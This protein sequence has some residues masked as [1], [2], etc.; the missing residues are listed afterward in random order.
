MTAALKRGEEVELPVGWVYITKR[1]P[2]R[3]A[4]GFQKLR[5]IADGNK[6]ESVS[7]LVGR[8]NRLICFRAKPELIEKGPFAPPPPPPPPPAAPKLLAKAEE[9]EQLFCALMQLHR[10]IQLEEF[11]SLLTAADGNLD[12]LVARLRQL[13]KEEHKFNNFIVLANTVRQLHW[14]R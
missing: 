14:I 7:R 3:K 11:K 5:N 9:V 10:E 6:K 2:G 8:P 12:R 4:R 1:P 13:L